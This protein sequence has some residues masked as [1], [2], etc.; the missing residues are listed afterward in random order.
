MS[1]SLSI[2]AGKLVVVQGREKSMS[3]R[4]GW[5]GSSGG[6]SAKTEAPSLVCV[7]TKRFGAG[8][9]HLLVAGAC[10]VV[11][12]GDLKRIVQ[13]LSLAIGTAAM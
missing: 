10:L 9:G 13:S 2:S 11:M 8:R 1:L 12:A 3:S 5:H 6:T 7:L 4:I